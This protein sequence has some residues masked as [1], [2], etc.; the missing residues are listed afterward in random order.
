M[1]IFRPSHIALAF[2]FAC[3]AAPSAAQQTGGSR[4][5]I[6]VMPYFGTAYSAAVQ[7]GLQI[8]VRPSANS[9]WTFFADYNRWVWGLVC[10]DYLLANEGGG[11]NYDD[12]CGEE[13]NAMH[14]GV[15]RTFGAGNWQPY[16]SAG[17]GLSEVVTRERDDRPSFLLETGVDVGGGRMLNGRLGLRYQ[18][19]P[20]AGGGGLHAD[21]AG[22]VVAFRVTF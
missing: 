19:R 21:F 9:E 4:P 22:P 6:G 17:A 10:V 3:A 8:Q 12:R 18:T 5:E 16:V 20:G 13:G 11:P 2:A 1:S 15:M 14:M 7:A